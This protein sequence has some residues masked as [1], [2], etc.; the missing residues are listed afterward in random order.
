MMFW[1]YERIE[2]EAIVFLD[3]YHVKRTIPVPIESIIE[4][5]LDISIVPR[6]GLLQDEQIDAFLSHDFTTIYID[7]DHYM[8]KTN[9]SR[10]TLA[11]EI[12]HYVMHKSIV[13]SIKTIQHW[14]S[15]ILGE[16][17][18][19][20]IYE[21]Q[22]NNFADCL[23]MPQPEIM[24]AYQE[25]ESIALQFLKAGIKMP[26]QKMLISYIATQIAKK[27]EVSEKAAEI[28]LSKIIPQCLELTAR[29]LCHETSI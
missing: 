21:S 18:G 2:E 5:N 19:R 11:H 28:R 24:V 22:A 26:D 10:F 27:F 8:N 9:R 15:F 3:T 4:C 29:D 20:A 1:S 16:G 25:L 23:L 7:Q 12:G 17:T 13:E 6:K 14:K